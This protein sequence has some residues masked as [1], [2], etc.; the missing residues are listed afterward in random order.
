MKID[1]TLL[2]IGFSVIIILL[3]FLVIKALGLE[4][5]ITSVLEDYEAV[6]VE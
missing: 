2:L 6:L 1:T 3:S 4:E 5:T